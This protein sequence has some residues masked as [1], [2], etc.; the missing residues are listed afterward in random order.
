[1][2]DE[3]TNINNPIKNRFKS[4]LAREFIY[5]I[6]TSIVCL[7]TYKI[8]EYYESKCKTELDKKIAELDGLPQHQLLWYKLRKD[9]LYNKNYENF[10]KDYKNTE[11]QIVLFNLVKNNNLYTN[12]LRDF[13]IKYFTKESVLD[14]CYN[15]YF[16]EYRLNDLLIE[17][18][19]KEFWNNLRKE[20]EKFKTILKNDSI[21]NK[22]YSL[23]VKN[24]YKHS[25]EKFKK[26]IFEP[27]KEGL[28]TKEIDSLEYNINKGVPQYSRTAKDICIYLFI[29]FFPFRYLVII[30]KWSIKEIKSK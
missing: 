27:Y 14:D 24:G 6:L 17:N 15:L 22:V 20:E 13:R 29:L 4:I 5:I 16:N 2:E 10:K 30:L 25:Y 1:M 26:L 28:N 9:K 12:E 23:F 19:D 7:S 8:G 18:Q 21:C 3:I 11:D